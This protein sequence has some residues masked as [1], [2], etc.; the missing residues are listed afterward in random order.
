MALA[1][2][3]DRAARNAPE[4]VRLVL[5]RNVRGGLSVKWCRRLT[6]WLDDPHVEP[7]AMRVR[8]RRASG[9]HA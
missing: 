7:C 9:S 1:V 5:M 3:S 4:E 2:T 8:S 6:S